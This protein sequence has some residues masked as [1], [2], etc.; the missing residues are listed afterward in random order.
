MWVKLIKNEKPLNQYVTFIHSF[1]QTISFITC[2]MAD[3]PTDRQTDIPNK[4][5]IKAL[6]DM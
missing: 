2:A 5:N 4:Q 3:R 1:I 6:L